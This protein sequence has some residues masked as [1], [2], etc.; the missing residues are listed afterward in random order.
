VPA[1]K[2]LLDRSLEARLQAVEPLRQAAAHL[3]ES[4]IDGLHLHRVGVHPP[5]GFAP[6]EAG[7]ALPWT[8][9]AGIRKTSQLFGKKDNIT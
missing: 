5:T 2:S 9:F 7:H 8:R 6:P 4:V 1:G 3:Q